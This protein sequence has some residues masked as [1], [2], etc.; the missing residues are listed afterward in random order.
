V[1]V[2]YA[3]SSVA[4]IIA[5]VPQGG[6]LSSILYNS[7]PLINQLTTSNTIVADYMDNNAILSI[8]SDPLLSIQH[9][10]FQL[11]IMED[12]YINWRFKID[13]FDPNLFSRRSP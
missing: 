12:W 6:N 11:T 1:R 13:Q 4:N 9:L 3:F 10:Q 7:I 2:G 5:D 8:H